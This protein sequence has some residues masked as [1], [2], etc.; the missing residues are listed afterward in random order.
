V[1]WV[2]GLAD[3]VAA[4]LPAVAADTLADLADGPVPPDAASAE[5][6]LEAGPVR[7]ALRRQSAGGGT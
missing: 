7:I 4:F 5:V 2:D 3:V 1:L 6:A